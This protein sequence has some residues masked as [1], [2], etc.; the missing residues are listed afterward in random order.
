MLRIAC[1]E[2]SKGQSFNAFLEQ[3][4]ARYEHDKLRA[5]LWARVT[6]TQVSLVSQDEASDVDVTKQASEEWLKK[7]TPG[8]KVLSMSHAPFRVCCSLC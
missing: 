6:D 1:T 4:A 2:N 5:D 7:H 3:M 8:P